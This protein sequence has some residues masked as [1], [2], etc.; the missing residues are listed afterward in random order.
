MSKR[1]AAARFRSF[2]LAE[3]GSM[4][5]LKLAARL[6]PCPQRS[7]LYLRHAQDESVHARMFAKQANAV[8]GALGQPSLPA[9]NADIEGLFEGLGELAFLAFVHLGE[10]RACSLFEAHRDHFARREPQT[11]KLFDR[12]LADEAQHATYTGTLL[13]ELAGSAEMAGKSLRRAQRWEAW[14][15]FRRLGRSLTGVLYRVSMWAL[16][17][18]CLPFAVLVWVLRPARPGFREGA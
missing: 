7:A 3:H 15:R 16:Y 2:A 10:R 6:T 9:P 12:I 14:R 17:A 18:G 1:R 4:L 8:R 5:D 13:V 11:A